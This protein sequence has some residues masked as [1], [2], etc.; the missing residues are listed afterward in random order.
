[1]K[2]VRWD[3]NKQPL[4]VGLRSVD[5]GPSFSGRVEEGSS[6]R[7]VHPQDVDRKSYRR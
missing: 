7:P 1:M 5:S 6:S 2:S 3:G 4:R